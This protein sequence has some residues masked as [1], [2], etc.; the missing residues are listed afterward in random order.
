[1]TDQI[2]LQ[3]GI[4]FL[5]VGKIDEAIE[6]LEKVTSLAPN[7]YRGF[8]FLGI[9]YAQK[10]LYNR[11]I[12]ALSTAVHLRPDVPSIHYNL[13]LAYQ[14]EGL[15]D[16]AR[17]QYQRALN[18][19]PIYEKADAAL[20]ALGVQT[21][22]ISEQACGRH[23]NEPAV[24]VCALCRLPVCEEC[25]VVVDGETYCSSCMPQE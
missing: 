23:S 14:A 25:R 1:M 22:S 3:Q 21:D 5:K 12:G 6:N 7:D 24:G 19:D 15:A 20:K 10:K 9:A 2:L 18:I 13:G 4:E 11:A 17:E 8:N 16:K